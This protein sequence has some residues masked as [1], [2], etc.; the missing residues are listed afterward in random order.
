MIIK[1]LTLE[2]FRVFRGS[3]EIE[4]APLPQDNELGYKPIILFGGLNGAGKTS[5]LTAVRLA[6]YGK[7]SLGYGCSIEDYKNYLQSL[8]HHG[9]F[10][11]LSVT[12]ASVTLTFDFNHNGE[13]HEY[14][15]KRSWNSG[16]IDKLKVFHGNSLKEELSYDQSQG[17]LNELIP[18]GVADLFF[19]DGEKIAELAEDSSGKILRTAVQRLLGLDLIARLQSDLSILL[20]RSNV[21]TMPENVKKQLFDLEEK[22]KKQEYKAEIIENEISILHTSIVSLKKELSQAEQSLSE[23]GGEW[24]KSR[25]SEESKLEHLL[26]E[27]IE[28][29]KAI[30]LE[31]D[32]F[33]PLSLAPNSLKELLVKL[34][35]E[36]EIKQKLA[37]KAQLNDFLQKVECSL[38]KQDG[39]V[40][41]TMRSLNNVA[42]H[43]SI[44][45]PDDIKLDISDRELG[46]LQYQITEASKSS[47]S[48][49]NET[50]SKLLTIEDQIEK[51]SVN[52]SRAPDQDRLNNHLQ[53]IRE[54]NSK[55]TNL[56][57]DRKS[58][59]NDAKKAYRDAASTARKLQS[60]HDKYRTDTNEAESI[61]YAQKANNL[62]TD[63]S[64]K[65]KLSRIMLL[66]S[67]FI[68]SYKKLA[69]KE[70]SK[71]YAEIDVDSFDVNL[72][73]EEN[74]KINRKTLSA[75]EKQIYAIAVLEALAKA[76]GHKLPV[77][78]DTPLGRL[79]SNHRDKLV[80][81]YFPQ[82]SHQVIIL[83]TD[84]EVDKQY[85]EAMKDSISHSYEIKYNSHEKSS[86]I[87]EGYFWINDTNMVM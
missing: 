77:I 11:E 10:S 82:A 56:L 22:Q 20:K 84:T 33:F 87:K 49:V 32:S 71:L 72:V 7:N 52:I 4:L 85:L 29:E 69:R 73:N 6:L 74:Q 42:R 57:L 16:Q 15:V 21:K 59:I 61:V 48:R 63:F 43:Y 78:I 62:L 41:S 3:H 37:F 76:S 65:I 31:M 8:I 5:I 70:D 39:D 17:F 83:S 53:V 64:E 18:T 38:E 79:D 47:K 24:A 2:N 25:Q 27:K 80:D 81:N 66:Q 34:E 26:I 68:E 45:D 55:L 75:G 51:L 67:A 36:S 86:E 12:R 14:T 9:P 13:T 54:L 28:L 1:K 50:I 58:L 60:L 46:Q 19:F 40:T 30:R 35:T 23:S 44:V